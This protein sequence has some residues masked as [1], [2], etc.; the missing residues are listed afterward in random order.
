MECAHVFPGD[1]LTITI[2]QTLGHYRILRPIG[3]GGMGEV[4]E[5]EDTRLGR[6]HHPHPA[7][8]DLLDQAVTRERAIRFEG[9][10]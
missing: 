1:P 8:T 9:Q 6:P 4:Y 5:A 7:L 2:G 10:G 3:A